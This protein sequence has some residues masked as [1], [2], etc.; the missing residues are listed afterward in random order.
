MHSYVTVAA[1]SRPV[2]EASR[3][4]TAKDLAALEMML[5]GLHTLAQPAACPVLREC[6]CVI[7]TSCTPLVHNESDHIVFLLSIG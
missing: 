6:R 1:L 3:L 4:R 2:T 5:S 7:A